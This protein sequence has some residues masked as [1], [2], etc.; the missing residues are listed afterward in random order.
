MCRIGIDYTAAI[1]QSAGIGRYTREIVRALASYSTGPF[2]PD[3]HLFVANGRQLKP[4]IPGPNFTWHYTPL[5]K[6]WLERLWYRLRLPLRIERW[7]GPLDLLHQPDFVL[8]PV[9]AGTRTLL[10][11]H[12]LSFIREP[13]SVMPG[14]MAHLTRWVHRSVARADHVIAVSKSTRQD[15]MELYQT[16]PEKITV[17]YH[18]VRPQFRPIE[19]P[20]ELAAVREKYGLGDRPFVLS[21]GTIQP[22]KNYQRLVRAFAQIK[23]DFSLVLAGSRGWDYQAVVDEVRKQGLENRIHFPNFVADPDLPALYSAASLFVYPS[24][25]EGFGLPVLEAMACGTPVVASDRSSLP[26]VVEEAGLLVDALDVDGMAAAMS[27]LLTDQSLHQQLSQA[28][29]LQAAKFTWEDVACKLI[30]L[31]QAILERR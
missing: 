22:R 26:E 16:P 20:A 21:V 18:G 2:R 7:T 19:D 23:L 1:H 29:R 12:D 31:Y 25:Y 14:M 8:P 13:N 6:R 27:K 28:G 24:L 10:T 15:L 9:K 4:V 5:T 30:T 11:V 17:L 3:Y